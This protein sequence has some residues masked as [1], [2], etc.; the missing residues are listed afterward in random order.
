MRCAKLCS[1][2]VVIIKTVEKFGIN[3][4]CGSSCI[5]KFKRQKGLVFLWPTDVFF[6][7]FFPRP[8]FWCKALFSN[9][10]S[11][12]KLIHLVTVKLN[13]PRAQSDSKFWFLGIWSSWSTFRWLE[14]FLF[15]PGT[16]EGRI[17]FAAGHTQTLY[18]VYLSCTHSKSETAKR[19]SSFFCLA[20]HEKNEHTFHTDLLY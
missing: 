8:K 20:S 1:T 4:L 3:E 5:V 9:L 18:C 6:W 13:T 10:F 7:F 11:S 15:N 16:K 2:S 19:E 12:V 17:L 14:S